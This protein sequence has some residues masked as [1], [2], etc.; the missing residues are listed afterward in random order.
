MKPRV[1][2]VVAHPDDETIFVGGT[3]AMFA[4][5][6]FEVWIA[7]ATRGE[8]GEMGD[9]PLTTRERLGRLREQELRCAARA[10]GASK[11]RFLGYVDPEVG[12]DGRLFAYT[13]DV[14]ELAGRII[15]LVKEAQPRVVITHGSSGE[16]G[17]PAHVITH[18]GVV[19]A[20][21]RLRSGGEAPFL[22]TFSAAIPTAQG[23]VLNA[24]DR[25]DVVVD[26]TPWLGAKAR[27]A[28]CH[29]TQHSLFFRYHPEADVVLD[30]LRSQESLH[31]VWPESGPDLDLLLPFCVIPAREGDD[32]RVGCAR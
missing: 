6:G 15:E 10:L 28:E 1:L 21:R 30:L 25:A 8:G 29:R 2:C 22:Y 23:P 7:S 13:D 32:R 20:H 19:A 11:V 14:D 12:K 3:L 18:R 27:A 31:R 9:P 16:Y 4:A 26:V 5:N 17:H 24:D